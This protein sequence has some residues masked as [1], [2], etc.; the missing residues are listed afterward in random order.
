MSQT[1][2]RGWSAPPGPGP[3]GP[4]SRNP[5][6]LISASACSLF[7]PVAA[8]CSSGCHRSIGLGSAEGLALVLSVL[9]F[10]VFVIFYGVLLMVRSLLTLVRFRFS[11]SRELLILLPWLL[12]SPCGSPSCCG[13]PFSASGST[14]GSPDPQPLSGC[15]AVVQWMP[16]HRSTAHPPKRMQP[17]CW[18]GRASSPPSVANQGASRGR[19]PALLGVGASASLGQ[20]L[21]PGFL[22]GTRRTDRGS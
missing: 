16:T 17:D 10:F 9:F 15:A 22:G 5:C 7:V 19:P 18:D 1:E 4:E 3:L 14:M 11:F 13:L 21:F 8:V 20:A 6:H 12:G 2:I